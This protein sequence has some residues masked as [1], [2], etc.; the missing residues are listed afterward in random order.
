MCVVTSDVE[1]KTI[2]VD[3]HDVLLHEMDIRSANEMR[4]SV[5]TNESKDGDS[6]HGSRTVFEIKDLG[7]TDMRVYVDDK[8]IIDAKSI[9]II[10]GGDCELESFIEAIRFAF[11]TLSLQKGLHNRVYYVDYC[12]EKTKKTRIFP[13][14]GQALSFAIDVSNKLH[15][16]DVSLTTEVI[17][18]K[19]T[20]IIKSR[21]DIENG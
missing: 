1:Y 9:K 8:K 11:K 18:D 4:V 5:G 6:G 10:F 21:E 14:A 17:C 12:D 19:K 13:N 20:I 7:A 15:I 16:K 2:K 3:S